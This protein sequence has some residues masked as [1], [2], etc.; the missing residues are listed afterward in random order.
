[1]PLVMR[2]DQPATAAVVFNDAF[3]EVT[4]A[5]GPVSWVISDP[6]VASAT[7]SADGLSAVITALA[8]DGRFTVQVSSGDLSGESDQIEIDPGAAVS[9]AISITMT[10]NEPAP[11]A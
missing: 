3:G 4:A 9:E 7:P 11:A 1:V 10:P 6:A 5:P 8:G 2:D